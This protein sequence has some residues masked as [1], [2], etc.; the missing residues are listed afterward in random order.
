MARKW[1]LFFHRNKSLKGI[2]S[3][4]GRFQRFV[5]LAFLGLIFSLGISIWPP[6]IAREASCSIAPATDPE[7]ISRNA[8][9]CY[10]EGK[11]D[12]AIEL[13]KEAAQI[14]RER[15]DISGETESKINLATA[16]QALGNYPQ[17]CKSLLQAFGGEQFDCKVLTENTIILQAELDA[18]GPASAGVTQLN[19]S[20]QDK[21][22]ALSPE[23]IGRLTSKSRQ[24]LGELKLLIETVE[25][26]PDSLNK[27][28]GL[29]RFGDI[30]GQ[31]GN[32]QVS[33]EILTQ[34]L[35]VARRLNSAQEESATLISLGN[36]EQAWGNSFSELQDPEKAARDLLLLEE[37]GILQDSP[38]GE[39]LAHLQRAATH[40]Q[41]AS[42]RSTSDSTK[43]Q[44]EINAL[45]LAIYSNQFR[46][47]DISQEVAGLERQIKGMLVNLP[48]SR[49][50]IYARINLV[51]TLT[52]IRAPIARDVQLLKEAVKQARMLKDRQA[53][54]YALGSLGKLY[55]AAGQLD[56]AQK[57]TAAALNV[58]EAFQ[59]PEVTYL[60]HWQQGRILNK[61]G[62]TS[63]AIEEYSQAFNDLETLR[64]DVASINSNVKFYFRDTVEPVYRDYVSLLLRSDNPSQENLQTAQQV[65]ESLQ[66]AELDNF[67][68]DPCS[69]AATEFIAINEVDPRAAVIYPIVLADRLEIILTLPGKPLRRYR[70]GV[71]QPE[72]ETT[73]EQL[74]E[75]AFRNPGVSERLRQARGNP[76]ARQIVQQDVQQTLSTQIWPRAEE[77][78]NWLLA[79][80]EGD[81]QESGVETLV[82]VLDG[83]LRNIP[84]ALLYDGEQYLLEKNYNIALTSSLQLL[85]PKPLAREAIDILAAGISQENEVEGEVFDPLPNVKVELEEKIKPVVE[86][87]EVLLDE[88]FTKDRFQSR[89]LA[90]NY[91]IVHL[92]TH[93]QFSSDLEETFIVTWDELI[94]INE[95]NSFLQQQNPDGSGKIDLLVLSACNTAEG[96]DRAVLGLAGVA[97][98]GGAGS[99]L[100]TLWGASDEAA[101][102]LMGEFYS[103]LT[104]EGTEVNKAEA[105]R[106]AQ[107]ALLEQDEYQHP[108][109]WAPFVLV[110]NWL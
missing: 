52:E 71:T 15:S 30:L 72:L 55:E 53:E 56:E 109:Y 83:D 35:D 59:K 79:P 1:R 2:F 91:N 54:A 9:E 104:A 84:M 94:D 76:Q 48:V 93:G 98:R 51:A 102:R 20:L 36:V 90:S 32:Y 6:A 27:A 8:G 88:E 73:I 66:I 60:W 23:Q 70:V 62:Q 99:T 14:Y 81:L 47:V 96:D 61:E 108:Y 86:D 50:T 39:A 18:I 25:A 3:R 24:F 49:A 105:L 4:W 58:T 7:E 78:Y 64:A 40:Y 65:I 46:P 11:H 100:G 110:G 101:A 80:L 19:F 82:F 68:S 12:L 43:V 34:S 75:Q 42:D 44:A 87:A 77:L 13:W 85:D 67:F 31:I 38:L 22:E 74:R 106:E 103:K 10:R 29:R 57:L 28:M 16:Q 97:V 26:Q 45:S 5:L 92:A 63:L 33:Q 17:A 21:L 107:L 37:Q 95:L 89:L 69:E 41:D